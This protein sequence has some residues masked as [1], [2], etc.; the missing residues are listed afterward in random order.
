MLGVSCQVR[1][2]D[3][4]RCRQGW[5]T[6]R[7]ESPFLCPPGSVIRR[8]SPLYRLWSRVSHSLSLQKQAREKVGLLLCAR[9]KLFFF[10]Y[11]SWNWRRSPI[12]TLHSVF[13]LSFRFFPFPEW[14]GIP[15]LDAS[16][17][18]KKGHEKDDGLFLC[19][20]LRRDIFEREEVF[21]AWTRETMRRR[22]VEDRRKRAKRLIFRFV[23]EDRMM[24]KR[25]AREIF[26]CLI[27]RLA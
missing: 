25:A 22:R 16:S 26:L 9:K 7:I 1:V 17:S 3:D 15:G 6:E 2:S 10:R 23:F 14:T 11:A 5:S 4:S 20:Y 13:S 18:P 24:T 19:P 12:Q 8:R 21:G 27:L